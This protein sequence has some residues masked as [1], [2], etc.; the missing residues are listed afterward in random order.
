MNKQELRDILF[1][2]LM[3]NIPDAIYLKDLKSR[4]LIINK[5][6]AGRNGFISPEE[7]VGKTDFDSFSEEHAR[8]AFEDE[9]NII[10]TGKPLINLMVYQ[11]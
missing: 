2:A 10:K 1:K 11:S 9:Q 4:F 5:A 3:D 7:A 6:C 8:Q